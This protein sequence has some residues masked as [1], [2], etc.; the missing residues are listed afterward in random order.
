MKF[1]NNVVNIFISI[2]NL[3]KW[4]YGAKGKRRKIWVRV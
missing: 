4:G 2:I 1:V 3:D